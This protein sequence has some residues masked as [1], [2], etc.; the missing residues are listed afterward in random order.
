ML[1]CIWNNGTLSCVFHSLYV[2]LVFSLRELCT[3]KIIGH[4]VVSIVIYCVF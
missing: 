4:L 3:L 1:L 2:V